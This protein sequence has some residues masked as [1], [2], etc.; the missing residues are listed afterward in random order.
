MMG[1]AS[2]PA[3]RGP[4]WKL[5]PDVE[6]TI[7]RS[8]KNIEQVMALVDMGAETLIIYGD[9]TKFHA[10]RMMIAG[11]GGQTIPVTQTWLKLGVGHLPPQE[12]LYSR[13]LLSQSWSIYW[14]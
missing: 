4:R 2:S 10:A 1:D 12:Y 5:R 11:F 13:C 14:P 8:Q 9:P 7:F 6:L 3:S